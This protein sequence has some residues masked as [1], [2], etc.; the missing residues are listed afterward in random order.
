[1]PLGAPVTVAAAFREGRKIYL[2][3]DAGVSDDTLIQSCADSKIV[4]RPHF[5]AAVAG[6][7][8]V[9]DVLEVLEVPKPPWLNVRQY[10]I[11]KWIPAFRAALHDAGI[12]LEA[13]SDDQLCYDSELILIVRSR[14]FVVDSDLAVCEPHIAVVGSGSAVALGALTCTKAEAPRKRLRRA[15]LAACDADLYCRRPIKVLEILRRY[16]DHKPKRKPKPKAAV[17]PKP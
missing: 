8:R 12:T 16:S 3:V 4:K 13:N 10:V 9:R 7:L 6:A 2:A 17:S 14:I 1:M 5:M 11:G 15:L